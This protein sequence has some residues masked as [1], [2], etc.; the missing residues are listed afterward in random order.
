MRK[1]STANTVL[2]WDM[3]IKSQNLAFKSIKSAGF[4]H[5]FSKRA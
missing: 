5:D 3:K 4:T 1:N 2:H